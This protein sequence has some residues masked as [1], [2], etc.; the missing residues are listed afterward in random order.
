MREDR[1]KSVT[2]KDVAK[3]AHVAPATASKALRGVGNVGPSLVAAVKQAA[4]DLGYRP[5]LSARALRSGR[6]GIVAVAIPQMPEGSEFRN[7]PGFW[8]RSIHTL[9]HEFLRA[10][11]CTIVTPRIGA[12]QLMKVP[13]DAL[14]VLTNDP[15]DLAMPLG[16]HPNT[17]LLVIGLDPDDAAGLDTVVDGN[18]F[19][20]GSAVVR[21]ALEHAVEN[22]AARPAIIAAN[23]PL[24][25]LKLLA[26]AATRWGDENGISPVVATTNDFFQTTLELVEQGCDA[27]IVFGDDAQPVL[28][29][30]VGAMAAADKRIPEDVLVAAN[31]SGGH[32]TALSPSITTFG[33]HGNELGRLAAD[34]VLLGLETGVFPPTA[35]PHYLVQRESTTRSS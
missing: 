21:A 19:G 13:C 14:V 32:A 6:L 29:A 22:G 20:G 27:F 5:D 17:P 30:V 25:P 7:A 23:E 10:D 33:R 12:E 16:H 15:N 1:P 34:W 3:R 8:E 11:F 4:M 31:S 18:Y 35:L 26:K 9:L 24:L 2:I 28:Q